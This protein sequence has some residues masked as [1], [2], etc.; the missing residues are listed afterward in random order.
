MELYEDLETGTALPDVRTQKRAQKAREVFFAHYHDLDKGTIPSIQP[1]CFEP[2][3][4][5]TN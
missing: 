3:T 1:V 2:Y 5:L 4:K